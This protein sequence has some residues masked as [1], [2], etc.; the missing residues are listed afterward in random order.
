[1]YL[2]PFF[3]FPGRWRCSNCQSVEASSSVKGVLDTE[4]AC[5]QPFFSL[6]L[7]PF[8]RS[9]KTSSPTLHKLS[10]QRYR[11]RRNHFAGFL[12]RFPFLFAALEDIGLATASGCIISRWGQGVLDVLLLSF[13]FFASV[14]ISGQEPHSNAFYKALG[15]AAGPPKPSFPPPPSMMKNLVTDGINMT[16]AE[17]FLFLQWRA[18]NYYPSSVG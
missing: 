5:S 14:L 2:T 17:V 15:A 18:S 1:L 16:T 9:I 3:F 13:S 4:G 12:P 8:S 7:S 11:K 6:F 10:G